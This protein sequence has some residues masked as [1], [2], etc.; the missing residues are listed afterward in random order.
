MTI[1]GIFTKSS[2]LD[3]WQGSDYSCL[4]IQLILSWRKFLPYR[5]QSIDL[6]SKLTDW[7]LYAMDLRH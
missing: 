4:C 2:I 6:Q 1:N 7:F 5:N 3:V